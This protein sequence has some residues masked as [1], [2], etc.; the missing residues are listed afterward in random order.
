MSLVS[1]GLPVFNGENYLQE[2][3]DSLLGQT[4]QDIELIIADNA[5]TD[6]TEDICR[7]AAAADGRVRYVRHP[8]N[9]GAAPNYNSTVDA[10]GGEFFMWNAHDDL[11]DPRFV[12]VALEGFKAMPDA[13]SVFGSVNQVH[14]DG[15]V[16][17]QN[18][19]PR[20]AY[21]NDVADRLRSVLTYRHPAYVIFGLMRRDVLNTTNR[22][23]AYPGADRVLAAELALRGPFGEIEAGLFSMRDHPNRYVK[24]QPGAAKSLWW[25]AARAGT[26]DAP[27]WTR[28]KAYRNAIAESDL[29]A[30]EKAR[31]RR[32]LRAAASDNGFAIPRG[33]VKDLF[34]AGRARLAQMASRSDD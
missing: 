24:K 12:E 20:A 21:S 15:R 29:S 25:D 26:I 31:C 23:G 33:V 2:A 28:L 17:T 11:R 10:A 32:A 4:Y 19:L 14:H 3:I 30:D 22:H 27:A 13:S 9:L 7:T 5:S 34:L 6:A 8:Q 18:D 16:R 1:I